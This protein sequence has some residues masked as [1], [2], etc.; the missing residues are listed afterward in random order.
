MI[1]LIKD[2]ICIHYTM[3]IITYSTIY[4]TPFKLVPKC[5]T[6]QLIAAQIFREY[7]PITWLPLK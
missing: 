5:K 6:K 4:T 2:K 3:Q 7:Q 1:L